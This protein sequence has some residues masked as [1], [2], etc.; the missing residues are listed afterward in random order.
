MRFNGSGE[1]F[2]AIMSNDMYCPEENLYAFL[3]N[4]D[5][6]ICVYDWITPEVAADLQKHAKEHDEYWGAFLGVGGEIYEFNDEDR[7]DP[8]DFCLQYCKCNWVKCEDV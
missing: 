8:L 5:D 3:Y 7:P 4:D 6:A 1:L 2:N